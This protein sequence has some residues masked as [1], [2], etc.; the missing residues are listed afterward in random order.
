MI[1]RMSLICPIAPDGDYWRLLNPGE[2]KVI[3]WAEGYFPSVRHCRVGMEPRATICD[4]ALI[5]MP[6]ERLKEIQAK[7]G[8]IPQDLRLRLRA[9]RLRKLRASTKAINRRR[10]KQQLQQEQQQRRKARASGG[11]RL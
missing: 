3:V 11:W 7:G 6:V 9:L 1:L 8:K 10:E 4:F 5:Q 2:Y